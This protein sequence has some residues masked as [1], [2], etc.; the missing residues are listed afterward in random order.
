MEQ[1]PKSVRRVRS[2]FDS[3]CRLCA[4]SQDKR[5]ER[6]LEV[7]RAEQGLCGLSSTR[8]LESCPSEPESLVFLVSFWGSRGSFLESRPIHFPQSDVPCYLTVVSADLT[9]LK[10]P[11]V[12]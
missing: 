1:Q 3:Q 9:S 6:L 10:I 5:T 12:S 4:K 8:E 7:E 2:D 11:M